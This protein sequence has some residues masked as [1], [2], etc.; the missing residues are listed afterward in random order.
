M[1]EV[2]RRRNLIRVLDRFPTLANEREI[3][4]AGDGGPLAR[5]LALRRCSQGRVWA[6][7]C[8]NLDEASD[9]FVDSLLEQGQRPLA[10]ADLDQG[11]FTCDIKVSI[12]VGNLN[13][14]AQASSYDI[15]Y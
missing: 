8:D 2:E 3:F 14:G 10:L 15:M 5:Y 13:D 12:G 11:S 6:A 4:L 1:S 7:F 9:I